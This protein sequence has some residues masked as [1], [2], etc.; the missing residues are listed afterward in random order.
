[1]Q[2]CMT[3]DDFLPWFAPQAI[4]LAQPVHHEPC[5]PILVTAGTYVSVGVADASGAR[6]IFGRTPSAG[7]AQ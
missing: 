7:D 1:M 2:S 6:G 4:R 3:L 5:Q